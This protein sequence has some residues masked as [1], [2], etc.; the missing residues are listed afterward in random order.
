VAT[1]KTQPASGEY[2]YFDIKYGS[3]EEELGEGMVAICKMAAAT[4]EDMKIMRQ[5]LKG[6]RESMNN[7]MNQQFQEMA[8][9]HNVISGE[10]LGTREELKRAVDNLVKLIQRFLEKPT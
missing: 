10:L 4:R 1:V 2:E 3:L 5:D 9:R 6:S 8:E 7:E